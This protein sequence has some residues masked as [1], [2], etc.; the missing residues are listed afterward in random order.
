M[1]F[2]IINKI[3]INLKYNKKIIKTKLNTND[4]NLIKIFLKL[5]LIKIIKKKNLNN[6]DII[7]NNN[8]LLKNIKN[9]YK[10]SHKKTISYNELKKITFKKKW[11][12]II[13]TKQGLLTNLEFIK[14]KTSGILIINLIY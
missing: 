14:K 12:L 7:L 1:F 3:K 5:N 4:L 8:Y 9:L 10:P 2:K 6:F 11:L 13:S